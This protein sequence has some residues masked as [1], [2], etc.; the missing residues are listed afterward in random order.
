MHKDSIRPGGGLDQ[1]EVVGDVLIDGIGAPHR[2]IIVSNNVRPSE[3]LLPPLFGAA[4]RPI[5][6]LD[7]ALAR[8]NGAIKR[9]EYAHILL[10]HPLGHVHWLVISIRRL[11]HRKVAEA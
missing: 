2:L 8:A 11:P 7:H 4:I 9:M 10:V 3:V 6:A 1:R 5:R